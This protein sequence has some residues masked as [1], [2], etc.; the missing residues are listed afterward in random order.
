MEVWRRSFDVSRESKTLRILS[1]RYSGI[2]GSSW[3]LFAWIPEDFLISV[4]LWHSLTSVLLV[5]LP[6]KMIALPHLVGR[7]SISFGKTI[8]IGAGT[9]SMVSVYSTVENYT[10]G[11]FCEIV[12]AWC[13]VY[14]GISPSNL[15]CMLPTYSQLVV[16]VV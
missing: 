5:G 12:T 1:R 11:R 2:V 6:R 3:L 14:P 15:A 10:L 4:I 16:F 7:I 13:F 8:P 9:V